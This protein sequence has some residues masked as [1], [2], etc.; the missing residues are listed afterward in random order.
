V[1][2]LLLPFPK[3]QRP[4][5]ILVPATNLES[6]HE[7]GTYV[8]VEAVGQ[9]RSYTNVTKQ[10]F[11]KRFIAQTVHKVCTRINYKIVPVTN[12]NNY[13]HYGKSGTEYYVSKYRRK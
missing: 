2:L 9:N 8:R 11:L 7:E 4:I 1:F 10:L 3:Q 12:L 13:L 5:G 6:D